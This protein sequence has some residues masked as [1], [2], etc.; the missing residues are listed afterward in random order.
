[1]WT[2]DALSGV[3]VDDV[4]GLVL[5]EEQIEQYSWD[6]IQGS[7]TFLQG[8]LDAAIPGSI[9]YTGFENTVREELRS[10]YINQY[11]LGI[12]GL[13]QMTTSDWGSIGGMLHEQYV[14]LSAFVDELRTGSI[15][16][17]EFRRRLNM[18]AN[19]SREAFE[20]AKQRAAQKMG[21]NEERWI[22]STKYENCDECLALAEMGWVSIGKLPFP[23]QGRTACLTNCHCTKEYRRSRSGE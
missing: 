7:T 10:L 16:E 11:L 17:E 9:E 14:W 13:D 15:S 23:G 19:S 8:L 3:F 1:M 4:T 22:V 21:F 2:R 18:Y 5:P 12:G 20:R 6:L